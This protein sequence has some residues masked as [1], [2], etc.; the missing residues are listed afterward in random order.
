MQKFVYF[1]N[2]VVHVDVR[3]AFIGLSER[4]IESLGM[5]VNIVESI[6][7]EKEIVLE[8]ATM[9]KYKKELPIEITADTSDNEYELLKYHIERSE[10]KKFEPVI[11]PSKLAN[12]APYDT[13]YSIPNL[14]QYDPRRSGRII[15]VGPKAL[16][17]PT[18]LK[19]MVMNAG[20]YG[21]LHY[22]PYDPTIWY[23]RG[24]IE[25]YSYKPEEVVSYLN[26]EL[27]YLL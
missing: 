25:P 15:K 14:P 13:L 18:V 16:I 24:D 10:P 26:S 22:G 20:L 2:A 8:L 27:S 23:Y 11:G 6:K 7:T 19:F 21:F 3:N 5:S 12:R 17:S 4:M 9:Y 1:D